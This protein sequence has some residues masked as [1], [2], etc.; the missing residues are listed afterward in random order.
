MIFNAGIKLWGKNAWRLTMPGRHSYWQ[1]LSKEQKEVVRDR[2]AK[3]QKEKVDVQLSEYTNR[4]LSEK[5]GISAPIISISVNGSY[6]YNISSTTKPSDLDAT[7]EIEHPFLL[8]SVIDGGQLFLE[9]GTSCANSLGVISTGLHGRCRHPKYLSEVY[10]HMTGGIPFNGRLFHRA[11]LNDGEKIAQAERLME[12]SRRML[13]S[14]NYRKAVLR[15]IEARAVLNLTKRF[16]SYKW[17][18]LDW[19]K[20]DIHNKVDV[21]TQKRME[22]ELKELIN[23]FRNDINDVLSSDPILRSQ[24]NLAM[25]VGISYDDWADSMVILRNNKRTEEDERFVLQK[26]DWT[27]DCILA[28]VTLFDSTRKELMLRYLLPPVSLGNRYIQKALEFN[29]KKIII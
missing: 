23:I 15:M 16:A 20:I 7:V 25:P 12:I 8:A 2:I 29:Q 5:F 18:I 22:Q 27:L 3:L 9:D 6:I 28:G 11:P 24:R 19:Q 17:Y 1:V 10:S 13:Y 14:G 21:V 4:W 26:N